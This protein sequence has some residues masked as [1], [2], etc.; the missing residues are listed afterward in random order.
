MKAVPLDVPEALLAQ[1]RAEGLDGQDEVWDGV[2]HMAPPPGDAHQE[3]AAELFVALAP[4]A[5]GLG[6]VARFETG[7]YRS[8]EDYRVPDQLYR[9]AE[10]GSER[11]AEAAELVVE[12]LPVHD[13]THEKLIWYAD[14]GVQEV[15]VI[16]PW[17]RT[18]DLYRAAGSRSCPSWP[19]MPGCG[20]RC[21]G[22]SS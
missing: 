1:R 18:A 19:A 22:S 21:S 5:K 17:D 9:R 10:D 6:L 14:R 7:L 11:G 16:N 12:I 20:P 3:V 4:L 13:K 15:L 8:T 2:L